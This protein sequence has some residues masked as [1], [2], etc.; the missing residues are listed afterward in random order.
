M[1]KYN[2]SLTFIKKLRTLCSLWSVHIYNYNYRFIDK[3]EY[4]DDMFIKKEEA[5]NYLT[6]STVVI[7][8]DEQTTENRVSAAS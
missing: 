7:V 6:A 4:P 3:E 8:V 5:E 1:V 2:Y